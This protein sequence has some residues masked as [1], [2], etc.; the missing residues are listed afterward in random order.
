MSSTTSYMA[1]FFML[2][3]GFMFGNWWIAQR[4]DAFRVDKGES[5]RKLLVSGPIIIG[6]PVAFFWVAFSAVQRFTIPINPFGENEF[7]N[8]FCTLSWVTVPFGAGQTWLL[9]TYLLRRWHPESP[10]WQTRDEAVRVGRWELWVTIFWLFLV[11]PI[12]LLVVRSL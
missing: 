3:G 12:A 10:E 7:W 1:M 5:I 8:F 2:Y 9:V 11:T 6:I 4:R